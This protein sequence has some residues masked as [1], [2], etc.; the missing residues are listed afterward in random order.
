MS[1]ANHE[2]GGRRPAGGRE[3]GWYGP[4]TPMTIGQATREDEARGKRGEPPLLVCFPSLLLS[5]PLSQISAFLPR[6]KTLLL[7][8]DELFLSSS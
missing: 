2:T 4:P 6:D 3:E 8:Y 7:A 5:V 1:C